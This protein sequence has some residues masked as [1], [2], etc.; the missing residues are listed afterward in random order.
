MKKF[1]CVA[2]TILTVFNLL[3]IPAYASEKIGVFLYGEYLDFDV[4]PQVIEG[5]TMVPM[6]KIF[7]SLGAT[8][9]WDNK[10]TKITATT[11]DAKIV[12]YIGSRTM[13]VNDKTVK[14]D[15]APQIVN[16]RTLVP[17]RAIAESLDTHVIWYDRLN[18]VILAPYIPYNDSALAFDRLK[19]YLLEFGTVYGN[20]TSIKWTE[21][22]GTKTEIMCYPDK[23]TICFSLSDNNTGALTHLYIDRG[24]NSAYY[25]SGDDNGNKVSGYINLSKYKDNY[26]LS[27]EKCETGKGYTTY[28]VVET[29]R[30]DINYMLE[31]CDISLAVHIT[32][33][34]LNT[35][36][37][38]NY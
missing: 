14:L 24:E 17:V 16:G 22:I 21:S 29:A 31:Q 37:F 1:I 9:K 3:C 30:N 15:V 27:Y 34:T 13:L 2:L 23:D 38:K 7:E 32:G 10:D 8:V 11:N 5:R 36:G 25:I 20:H 26:P 28:N 35:L 6:R 4:P 33:V 19:N 12:M 18:T